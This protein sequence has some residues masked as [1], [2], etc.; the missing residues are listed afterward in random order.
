MENQEI[1]KVIQDFM[2]KSPKY[3]GKPCRKGCNCLE[4]AEYKAQGGVKEYPCLHN[5]KH[6][7]DLKPLRGMENRIAF[8][9]G[10]RP[11]WTE[12]LINYLPHGTVLKCAYLGSEF[13]YNGEKIFTEGDGSINTAVETWRWFADGDGNFAEI[14]SLPEHN[15]K[16]FYTSNEFKEIIDLA[17]ERSQ[18]I[19]LI[20]GE[21]SDPEFH[22]DEIVECTFY[23]KKDQWR[24][25]KYGGFMNGRHWV[26]IIDDAHLQAIH[27]IRKIV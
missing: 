6:I 22:P 26:K 18:V 13:T 7:E 16:I 4:M 5:S 27:E 23:D 20:A 21:K 19:E 8:K 15:E 3:N 9:V 17:K 10:D 24:K 12:E 25:M 11:K 1:K 14:I 2:D